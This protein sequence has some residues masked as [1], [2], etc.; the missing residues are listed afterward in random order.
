MQFD[1]FRNCKT[2]EANAEEES[3]VSFSTFCL[4]QS[5]TMPYWPGIGYWR[6]G[7]PGTHKIPPGSVLGLKTCTIAHV[8]KVSYDYRNVSNSVPED[9]KTFAIF[10]ISLYFP[11]KKTFKI[12]WACRITLRNPAMRILRFWI[13]IRNTIKGGNIYQLM[14][15]ITYYTQ[16]HSGTPWIKRKPHKKSNDNYPLTNPGK[17]ESVTWF[18]CFSV[19]KIFS[20]KYKATK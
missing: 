17:N 14:R 13:K 12:V 20:M 3:S 2:I 5:L 16:T 4:R 18:I 9:A 6:S 8:V 1:I 7:W 19:S 11:R 10:R 15:K